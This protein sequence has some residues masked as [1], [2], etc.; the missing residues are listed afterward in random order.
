MIPVGRCCVFVLLILVMAVSASGQDSSQ[1]Q[2]RFSVGG[3]FIVSQPKEE[4][5]LNVGN[6][7][8]GNGT[9]M[10][11]LLRSGL[12]NLRFDMS[13][14]QYDS[15]KT[16]VP[17]S[18]TIGGRILVDV[19]TRN[20]IV[21]MSWG[22]EFAVPHGRIRPYVNAAYSRLFFR[23]TSSVEGLGSFDEEISST[24]NFKD[25]TGAWVYGG[26]IRIPLS[27]RTP[28]S[29]DLGLRYH[30]G[31]NASYLRAG[32]IQDNLDGSVT[33]FP[34]SSR[35]PFLMYTVGVQFRIPHG[36]SS[37]SSFLC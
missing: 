26:G 17:L 23:T 28:I 12:V 11:H 30:R 20:S 14:V 35:T 9:V 32:S 3:S 18:E 5:R 21:A 34:L 31:G 13:G 2:T 7:Y 36:S 22:P 25:G 16:R 37:C 1:I 15:E 8:G 24:T 19:T 6:G 4:F 27:Q 10:Y 29:L 33:I